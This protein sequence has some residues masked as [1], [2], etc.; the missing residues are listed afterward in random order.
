MASGTKAAVAACFVLVTVLITY[1]FADHLTNLAPSAVLTWGL[2]SR[3]IGLVH[4]VVFASFDGQVVPLC[5]K[6]GVTPVA[7]FLAQVREDFPGLKKWAYFPTLLWLGDSDAILQLTNRA[8]LIGGLLAIYGGIFGWLGL[9]LSRLAL[10]SLAVTGEF[11]FV[12]DYMVFEAGALVL[13]LPQ[14]L[15]LHAG[16]GASHLP[17]PCVALAWQLL[18]IR[19]M[20]GFAKTKFSNANVAKDNLFLQGFF[21]WQLLPNKL[22]WHLHHAPLWILRALYGGMIYVEVVLPFCGFFSGAPRC[23]GAW[24]LILLMFG[25]FLT[26]NWGQFNIGYALVCVGLFDLE[27]QWSFSTFFSGSWLLPPLMLVYVFISLINGLFDTWTNTSWPWFNW[28]IIPGFE[29]HGLIGLVRLLAPFRLINAYGVFPPEALPHVRSSMVFQGSNDGQSWTTYPYKYQPHEATS[30]PQWFAPH[31]ARLDHRVYY[32]FEMTSKS[33]L[34]SAYCVTDHNPYCFSMEGFMHRMSQR[35]LEG[36]PSVL[37]LF[38]KNPFSDKPPALLRVVAYGVTPTSW[39]H[40]KATGNWWHAQQLCELI[41]PRKDDPSLWKRW[42][43]KPECFHPEHEIW[44]RRCPETKALLEIASAEE[45]NVD[46]LVRGNSM[47]SAEEVESFWRDFIT[48]AKPSHGDWKTIVARG[49]A[50]AARFSREKLAMYERIMARYVLLLRSRVT[51]DVINEIGLSCLFGNWKLHLLVHDVISEGKDAYLAAWKDPHV[52]VTRAKQI[53]EA[54]LLDL[55]GIL[56]LDD[57]LFEDLKFHYMISLKHRPDREG[58]ITRAVE[59]DKG[60]FYSMLQ[61]ILKEPPIAD[62]WLPKARLLDSGA[63]VVEGYEDQPKGNPLAEP[64][65]K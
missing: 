52:L 54:R 30:R 10:Q 31:H 61:F 60:G 64:M 45:S 3:G 37:S 9:F 32:P 16:L 2:V 22:A 57:L 50:C 5:G 43:P 29:L 12:W 39:A 1:R 51:R 62:L 23:F 63:W 36:E 26:G 35:L 7:Q 4:I 18:A 55:I 27:I 11:W 13:L 44:F 14:A 25:I 58:F 24:G 15:P 47:I 41:S 49:R 56:R 59:M 53:D 17:V 38:A 42:V 46:A 40:H 33:D 20:L 6:K 34:T 19:L 48:A 8:G 28:E 21:V 65:L